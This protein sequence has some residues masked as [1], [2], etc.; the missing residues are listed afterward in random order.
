MK[1]RELA[2]VSKKKTSSRETKEMFKSRFKK[3]YL[4]LSVAGRAILQLQ[5]VSMAMFAACTFLPAI[6]DPTNYQP[7]PAALGFSRRLIVQKL[8]LGKRRH[9]SIF[10]G[11]TRNTDM[12]VVQL[13]ITLTSIAWALSSCRVS[14]REEQWT[15]PLSAMKN[16]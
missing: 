3:T 13:L 5:P 16:G 12:C 2:V 1:C 14:S 11:R 15:S 10:F 6:I 4:H 8:E 9:S 7:P